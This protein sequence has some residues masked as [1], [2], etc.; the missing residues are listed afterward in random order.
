MPNSIYIIKAANLMRI[1]LLLALVFSTSVFADEKLLT[2]TYPYNDEVKESMLKY[3][4]LY[5]ESNFSFC[6]ETNIAYQA[7]I[8]FDARGISQQEFRGAE[9]E[10]VIFGCELDGRIYPANMTVSPNKLFFTHPSNSFTVDREDLTAIS[11]WS[12]GEHNPYQCTLEDVSK[13]K[14]I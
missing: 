9:I 1:F 5:D 2:C 11:N 12:G 4:S 8:S 14:A 13:K 6:E 3:S 7:K 10:I